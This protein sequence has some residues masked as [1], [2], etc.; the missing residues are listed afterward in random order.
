MSNRTDI[1][2]TAL[3]VPHHSAHGVLTYWGPIEA[4]LVAEVEPIWAARWDGE[5]YGYA[6]VVLLVPAD[7]N[8]ECVV[9]LTRPG[10]D[11]DVVAYGDLRSAGLDD[12]ADALEREVVGIG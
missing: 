6:D 11:P 9:V 7:P 3:T 1:E 4:R 2:P 12:V 8:D 5:P 10:A